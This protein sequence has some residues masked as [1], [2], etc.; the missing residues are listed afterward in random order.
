MTNKTK[1]KINKYPSFSTGTERLLDM[2]DL[3]H[4]VT[5]LLSTPL[6]KH[7]PAPWATGSDF[8][9]LQDELEEHLLR[10]P[11]IFRMNHKGP[12]DTSIGED[13]DDSISSLI[14]HCSAI[15]LSRVFLP[16]PERSTT[17]PSRETQT[18]HLR[19]IDFPGAPPLF[20]K[21]R[22]RRCEA[23]AS[24]ICD[25]IQDI[26]SRGGFFIVS[27]ASNYASLAVS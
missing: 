1:P 8:R 5:G 2:L 13:V 22:M 27:P 11:S 26:I 15:L 17:S 14:W 25:I 6:V 9:A 24:A 4:R 23:S 10:D 3:L 20:L 19:F 21:D 12:L 7:S 16:I 18:P